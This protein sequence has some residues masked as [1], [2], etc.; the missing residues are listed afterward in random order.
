MTES[1]LIHFFLRIRRRFGQHARELRDT[2]NWNRY[3]IGARGHASFLVA[4]VISCYSCL[5]SFYICIIQLTAF[6][7][8]KLHNLLT[9]VQIEQLA[10][11]LMSESIR[12]NFG[13]SFIHTNIEIQTAYSI[14]IEK[15][16]LK[17]SMIQ[18][19]LLLNSDIEIYWLSIPMPKNVEIFFGS[20]ENGQ[21]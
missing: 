12:T 7:V 3:N 5:I 21:N 19:F 6:G 16:H 2:V 8:H 4:H 18:S 9:E 1:N 13:A 11:C 10:I 15:H 20:Y 14:P 17:C